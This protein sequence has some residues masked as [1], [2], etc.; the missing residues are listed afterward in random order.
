MIN[1]A[2]LE[3]WAVRLYMYVNRYKIKKG[4]KFCRQAA[5]AKRASYFRDEYLV[6]WIDTLITEMEVS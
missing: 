3:K 6:Q 4:S 5:I 2:K 1:R